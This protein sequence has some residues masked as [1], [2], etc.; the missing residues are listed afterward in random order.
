MDR[1][2]TI[3]Q[4]EKEY[5]DD[6]YEK[7]AVF[8]LGSWLHHPVKTVMELMNHFDDQDE[9]KI[10]DLGSGVGRNSIPLAERLKDRK[11]SVV[12][13]DLLASAISKL[14][15][16]S[17]QYKVQDK[18]QPILADISEYGITANAYDF[19]FSVS[20][21]EHIATETEFDSVLDRMIAGTKVHG[22]N[23]IIISTGV[24]ETLVE[25]GK[26]LDPMFE[27]LFDTAPLIHKLQE[28]YR[29][30]TLL[31]QTV[32]HFGVDITREGQQVFLESN[33]LTWAVQKR[34]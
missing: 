3:R 30:W 24:T 11:G 29:G 15:S 22:I 33:V 19:I 14:S 12:C 21:L 18:I 4:K 25:S 10:L 20:A 7:H 2:S 28:C 8:E 31:K 34:S 1:I 13:V 27:L 23:C 5:H 6:C 26:S 9:V 32:R 17:E 16:Y